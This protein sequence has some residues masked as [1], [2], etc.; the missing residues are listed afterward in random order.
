MLRNSTPLKW[1]PH[2]AS[3]TLDSTT[4]F[5]GAMASLQ[6]LI[7]DPSTDDLW[8]CRPAALLLNDLA[9]TFNT[10]TFISATLVVGNRLYGMVSTA[11]NPGQDEPFCYNITTNTFTVISGVTALNTPVSP[12]QNGAWNPPVMSLI[13]TKI[14]VAH[15]G[16][17]GSGGVFFGVIDTTNQN[18][19]T[20]SGTNTTVNS[21]PFPPQW[22]ANFNGRCYYLVNVPNGQP[23]AYFSDILN[24][25]VITNANQVLTFGDNVQLTCAGG[26]ALFNQLGGIV[27]SLMVFKSVANIYQI[28]GDAAL[29]NL[30]LN[31]LNVAT[32]TLS[33]NS[34][35]TTTKGLAFL[36]PDGLRIIDFTA[37]VSDPIGRSGKGITI[38][39]FF[40]LVP[41]RANASFNGGVFRAQVQNG[42]ALGSPQQEWWYDMVRD[43]WSGPHT[44]NVSMIEPYANTFLIT[45]IG[46]GAK[47]YQSDQVQSG[48]SNFVEYGAQLSY[49]FQTAFFPNTDQMAQN[50]I[51]EATLMAALV[52]TFN[53]VCAALDQNGVVLDI[54]TIL[55]TGQA[56]LWG[57][58]NWGQA[59]WGGAANNLAPRQ[60]LWHQPLVFQRLTLAFT[61]LSASGIKLGR[62]NL[63]YQIL[64][65]LL[66]DTASLPTVPAIQTIGRFTLNANAT[67]TVVVASVT[68]ASKIFISPTTPDAANDEATTSIVAGVGS[69]TVTH[70]NNPRVD[71]TFD[72][73]AVG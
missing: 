66:A 48:T 64:G 60:L 42:L 5:D 23:G 29:N 18:A 46:R 73:M 35:S 10:P 7:P 30:S 6:N 41:S 40:S 58:F 65:Y 32:G 57:Q 38:P 67:T 61:G 15:P 20:W 2:G 34:L 22:V 62:L 36:A 39:F 37:R 49:A 9:T 51:I 31:T 28:T 69:F 26:L 53:I 59:L 4:S 43:E 54:V 24:P 45:S 3:D 27:Q 17:N 8:Q 56:T 25:T 47:I 70:A 71:R 1:S 14:I 13:G 19:L 68:T 50:C 63:R 33:P 21:L 16:F 52:S 11:R 12:S 55:A 44:T 72:W